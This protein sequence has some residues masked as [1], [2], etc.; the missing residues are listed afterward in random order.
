MENAKPQ[1]AVEIYGLTKA[2]HLNGKRGRLIRYVKKDK[3]WAVATET[4]ESAVKIKPVNLKLLGSGTATVVPDH[5]SVKEVL[6]ETNLISNIFEFLHWKDILRARVCCDWREAAKLAQVPES[7]TDDGWHT[8]ELY[9]QNRKIAE[10]IGWIADALPGMSSVNFLFE[11]KKS[12]EFKFAKGEDPRNVLEPFYSPD[13]SLDEDRPRPEIPRPVDISPIANFRRLR[14]LRIKQADLN[15]SYPFLFDF[16]NLRTLELIDI[17]RLR[18]DLDMLSGLPKLEK[19]RCIRV[20]VTGTLKCLRVI[21]G[22]LVDLCLAGC[23]EVEGNMMDLADFPLLKELSLNNCD[24]VV[25]DITDIGP[26]DFQSIESAFTDLPDSVYGA[27][28]LPSIAETPKIMQAWY[29][30]KKRNQHIFSGRRMSL[31]LYSPER[32]DNNVHHSR[33]MPKCVEFVSAGPR[34]GWR[35][36]NAVNGGSCETNWIDPAPNPSDVNYD[37]YLKELKEIER[38]VDFFKGFFKPPT[39]QEHLQLNSNIPLDPILQRLH[40][41]QQRGQDGFGF[42]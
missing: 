22:S 8:R 15:G 29:T 26:A 34:L 31:S 11:L 36:T 20:P 18:W 17:G 41:Q 2:T 32:Y 28:H 33:D 12:E 37:V 4:L 25:C 27:G 9:V 19:L 7:I 42:W 40:Q 5:P 35:W 16:P 3:R 6:S 38:D 1:D 30:L 14:N 21:R 39:Q 10:A 13:Y 23:S 24:K